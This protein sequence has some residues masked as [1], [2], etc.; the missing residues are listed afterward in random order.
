MFK[1]YDELMAA[2][3]HRRKDELVLEIDLGAEYSPEHEQAKRELKQ[4]EGMKMLTGNQQ[5]LSDNIAALQARVAET[6]PEAKPVWVRYRRLELLEWAALTKTANGN[7]IEQYETVLKKTFIG[8]YATE[9]KSEE[10]LSD[11]HRLL[12]TKGDL[13]IL[14]GGAMH[15]VVQAFMAWQN[16]GGD[17]NIRPTKSGQD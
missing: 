8:V 15:S 17:V 1:S 13:G 12:S 14:P 5:F 6:K 7:A 16:S 10:P 3:E 4:A 9:E 11:D 2:V